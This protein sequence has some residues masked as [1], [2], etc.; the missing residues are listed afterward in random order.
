MF[1]LRN[2]DWNCTRFSSIYDVLHERRDDAAMTKVQFG[3][4]GRCVPDDGSW[5]NNI[6]STPHIVWSLLAARRVGWPSHTHTKYIPCIY[7]WMRRNIYSSTYEIWSHKH[8]YTYANRRDLMCWRQKRGWFTNSPPF[9]LSV[10]SLCVYVSNILFD[11]LSGN[12]Y[13]I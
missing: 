12:I 7:I 1:G 5:L 2:H 10:F 13:T 6:S 8:T 11:S 3:M 9:S 4:F